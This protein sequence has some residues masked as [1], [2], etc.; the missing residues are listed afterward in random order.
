MKLFPN[1]D[2]GLPIEFSDFGRAIVLYRLSSIGVG[3]L[4][5]GISAYQCVRLALA[6]L[7]PALKFLNVYDEIA[8]Y[9][10]GLEHWRQ[11]DD[12]LYREAILRSH[13]SDSSF[14]LF[15]YTEN[16]FL[17]E[18]SDEPWFERR[19]SVLAA[20]STYRSKFV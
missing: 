18:R 2:C 16:P 11:Q 14:D 12:F 7:S 8:T 10:V 9:I 17:F 1:F 19:Y 13:Q 3:G 15:V 4:G 6:D 20:L 5:D